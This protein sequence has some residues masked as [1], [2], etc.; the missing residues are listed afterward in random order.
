MKN[1]Y[2]GETEDGLDWNDLEDDEFWE[3]LSND[4]E[5]LGYNPKTKEF[6]WREM[7]HYRYEKKTDFFYYYGDE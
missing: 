1:H 6:E 3:E 5:E 2:V 7:S 4:M